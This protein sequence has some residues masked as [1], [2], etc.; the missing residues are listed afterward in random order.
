MRRD[1]QTRR[2]ALIAAASEC[3]RAKGYLVP[4]EEVAALAGVGRG[5]LYRNFKDRVAL[6]IAV[7]DVELDRIEAGLDP[8]MPL[9]R[10]IA[11]MALAGVQASTLFDRMAADLPMEGETHAALEEL[12][13][14]LERILAPFVDRAHAD[15]SL[16]RHVTPRQAVLALR[17]LGGLL[18]PQQ[19]RDDAEAMLAEAMPVLLHGL[20]PRINQG[21]GGVDEPS[22]VEASPVEPSPVEPSPVEPSPV[23]PGP[24]QPSPSAF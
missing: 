11:A 22:P 14:R 7:F 10:T 24:V 3:F 13:R 23:D 6:L 8:A 21:A 2:D 4:L 16:D 19:S 20:R 18:L 5:T 17:M 1:A 15:G 9:H 12:A